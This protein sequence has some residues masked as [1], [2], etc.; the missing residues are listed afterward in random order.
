MKTCKQK[1]GPPPGSRITPPGYGTKRKARVL[2]DTAQYQTDVERKIADNVY[3][4]INLVLR[5]KPKENNFKAILHTIRDLMNSPAAVPSWLHDV[6]LGYGDPSQAQGAQIEG[7]ID[8]RDTFLSYDHLCQ[9]LPDLN[10]QLTGHLAPQPPFQL[11]FGDGSGT[12][13]K[14]LLTVL[15]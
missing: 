3:G 15:R 9:S 2:L 12:L 13:V 8:F 1:V 5:R 10:V 4:S 11:Q 7:W 14:L 6:F